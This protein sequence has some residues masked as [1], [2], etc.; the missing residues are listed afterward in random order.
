MDRKHGGIEKTFCCLNAPARD[1]AK[2][3]SLYLHQGR[4][5]GQQLVPA[6]WVARSTAVDTTDGSVAHYQYQWWLPSADGDF[7]A[8]G[9]L[10]QYI[11]VD[12]TRGLVVVRLGRKVGGVHWPQVFRG[13]AKHY[14]P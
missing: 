13:I 5:R 1:F 10:G 2:I 7:M 4:W 8:Q 14:E 11:Y 6:E 3:G 9:I 12:P